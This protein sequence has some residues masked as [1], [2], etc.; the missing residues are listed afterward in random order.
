MLAAVRVRGVPDTPRSVSDTLQSLNLEQKHACV[1]LEDTA[2]TRG[3]LDAVKDFVAYGPVED[4]TVA[5]L[6]ERGDAPFHLSPPSGGFS[7][8]KR[9]VGQGGSVGKREDMDDLL[10]RML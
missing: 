4:D 8:P 5:A 3:M 10:D 7:D 9:R 6:Q 1:L 2:A